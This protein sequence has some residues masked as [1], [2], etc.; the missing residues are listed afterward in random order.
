MKP[1]TV[2]IINAEKWSGLVELLGEIGFDPVV[3]RTMHEALSDIHPGRYTAIFVGRDS[4]QVD[5]L[6]FILNVRDVDVDTPIIVVGR[7]MERNLE[8]QISNQR[9]IVRLN[10]QPDQVARRLRELFSGYC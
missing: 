3:R 5:V 9:R 4:E 2:L 8:E 1:T 10:K 6:E 7:P